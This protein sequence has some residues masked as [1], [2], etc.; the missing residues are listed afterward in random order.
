MT[1]AHDAQNAVVA[2][3]ILMPRGRRAIAVGIGLTHAD[4]V[5]R[6]GCLRL[7]HTGERND[8]QNLAPCGEHQGGKTNGA[9]PSV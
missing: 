1:D 8:K 4:A 5:E 3:V 6:I 9:Y 2:G 7:R